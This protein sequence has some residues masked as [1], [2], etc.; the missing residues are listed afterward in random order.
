MK[1]LR[2]IKLGK[3]GIGGNRL[4]RSLRLQGKKNEQVGCVRG[5]KKISNNAH[6]RGEKP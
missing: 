4:Y 6:L 5:K 2:D 1:V 3:G